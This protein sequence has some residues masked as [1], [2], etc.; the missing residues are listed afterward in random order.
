MEPS[1]ARPVSAR[2]SAGVCTILRGKA[3]NAT[4]FCACSSSAFL[5]SAGSPKQ[6]EVLPGRS[7][8]ELPA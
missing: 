2:L 6:F 5:S 3:L 7:F 8:K 4:G 1:T